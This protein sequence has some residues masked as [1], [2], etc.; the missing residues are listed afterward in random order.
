MLIELSQLPQIIQEQILTAKADNTLQIVQNGQVIKQYTAQ[1]DEQAYYDWFYEHFDI[2]RMKEA[3]GETEEN[4]QA[5]G[6]EVPKWALADLAS[7][8][9]WLAGAKS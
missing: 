6:Q 2:E 4:G 9:R 7:F 8:D 1:D 5:K 3:I